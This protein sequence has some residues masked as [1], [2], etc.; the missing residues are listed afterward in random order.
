MFDFPIF[1]KNYFFIKF[2]SWG[3]VMEV[4]SVKNVKFPIINTTIVVPS[5]AIFSLVSQN[6]IFGPIIV[7]PKNYF[8]KYTLI[9]LLTFQLRKLIFY[10]FYLN[11]QSICQKLHQHIS[12]LYNLFLLVKLNQV[13]DQL[14]I[15]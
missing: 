4:N 11:R 1:T 8:F 5:A 12:T 14:L 7:T 9:S 2:I 10:A 15:C 6:K 13:R 3:T